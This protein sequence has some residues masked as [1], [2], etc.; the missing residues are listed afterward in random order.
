MADQYAHAYGYLSNPAV[1]EHH[2]FRPFYEANYAEFGGWAP[3]QA[4][5]EA[6][7]LPLVLRPERSDTRRPASPPPPQKHRNLAKKHLSPPPPLHQSTS[8]PLARPHRSQSPI[9]LTNPSDYDTGGRHLDGVIPQGLTRFLLAPVRPTLIGTYVLPAL[10]L[11]RLMATVLQLGLDSTLARIIVTPG[12]PAGVY[13]FSDPVAL[14]N[15]LLDSV[16]PR[17]PHED[18]LSSVYLPICL[19]CHQGVTLTSDARLPTI[20]VVLHG[21][22]EGMAYHNIC[23]AACAADVLLRNGAYGTRRADLAAL[24]LLAAARVYKAPISPP[25]ATR[26]Q[27]VD[28]ANTY[29]AEHT[30]R[31]QN[32]AAELKKH[33][34]PALAPATDGTGASTSKDRTT[35][36]GEA[37]PSPP[38]V[39]DFPQPIPLFAVSDELEAVMTLIQTAHPRWN[40]TPPGLSNP[41]VGYPTV[42]RFS[43]PK[44]GDKNR[45]VPPLNPPNMSIDRV[46]EETVLVIG[47]PLSIW[48]L[49]TAPRPP[50]RQDFPRDGPPNH[51]PPSPACGLLIQWESE[52]L[53]LAAIAVSAL[54]TLHTPGSNMLARHHIPPRSLLLPETPGLLPDYHPALLVDAVDTTGGRYP[55]AFVTSSDGRPLPLYTFLNTSPSDQKPSSL[56]GL[57]ATP[58]QVQQLVLPP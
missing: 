32:F 37:K 27:M 4:R 38:P 31:E 1:P 18:P 3:Y 20:S 34:A 15:T 16:A 49:R 6:T 53:Q 2:H 14:Y 17:T 7:T 57:V 24:S 48:P 56:A 40:R 33:V 30:T 41:A 44:E 46:L 13:R 11:E 50:N 51:E 26:D 12:I 23:A 45:I 36:D 25:P 58:L 52:R 42:I 29:L 22:E 19:F 9:S 10:Y 8:H 21:L 55:P 28:I 5:I 43:P 39:R 54:P 35:E 47:T